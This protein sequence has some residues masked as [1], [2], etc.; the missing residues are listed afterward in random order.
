MTRDDPLTPMVG[1]SVL[2]AGAQWIEATMLGTVATVIAII[3]IASLGLA[4]LSGRI[5]LR[6]AGWTLLGC[7]I[8]FG[9]SAIS[10]G[11][12]STSNRL[13]LLKTPAK[14]ETS[15]SIS[16]VPGKR[17]NNDPYAGASMPL[18]N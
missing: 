8:V 6:R 12:L 17:S 9:A 14:R 10:F 13:F 5:D 18:Q 4:M 15:H 7:F 3:A 2:P 16:T 11:V 1:R